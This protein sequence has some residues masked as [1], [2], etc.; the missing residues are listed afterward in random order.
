MTENPDLI[1][2]GYRVHKIL[3][4]VKELLFFSFTPRRIAKRRGEFCLVFDVSF[5]HDFSTALAV[6][7]SAGR[8]VGKLIV[9]KS[10]S[11]SPVGK[12]VGR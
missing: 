8:V 4:Y 2:K 10:F 12:R 5:P 6:K 3:L 7:R 1:W 9:L 11:I